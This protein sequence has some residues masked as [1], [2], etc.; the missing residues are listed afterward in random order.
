MGARKSYPVS[1][2]AD[3]IYR[4]GAS[5]Q[6]V[7]K[8]YGVSCAVV[9][10]RLYRAGHPKIRTMRA[11]KP[12]SKVLT[13]KAVRIVR[14]ARKR[15]VSWNELALDHHV[16]ASRLRGI[17]RHQCVKRGWA[18]PIPVQGDY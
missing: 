9:R 4:H 3:M 14:D 1:V 6:Y 18:W 11:D 7:A 10:T 13:D 12:R 17:M 5:V 15:G 16:S 8:E 2:W